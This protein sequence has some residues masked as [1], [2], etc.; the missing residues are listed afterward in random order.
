MSEP[1]T[2]QY[3]ASLCDDNGTL[4]TQAVFDARIA[5]VAGMSL[6]CAVE[7]YEAR[8][9]GQTVKEM[10]IFLDDYSKYKMQQSEVTITIGG[11][12]AS[13]GV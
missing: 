6:A 8:T 1:T 2:R 9:D 10:F 11:A 5:I 4:H 3:P 12:D 13:G 7:G